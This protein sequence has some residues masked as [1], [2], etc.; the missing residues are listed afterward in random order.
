[1]WGFW[2]TEAPLAFVTAFFYHIGLDI[3]IL[4]TE[5]T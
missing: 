1:M 5:I 3:V 2:Y 4:N